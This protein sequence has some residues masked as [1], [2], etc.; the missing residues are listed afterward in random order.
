MIARLAFHIKTQR[1]AELGQRFVEINERPVMPRARARWVGEAGTAG[2]M[3]TQ[4]FVL[5]TQDEIGYAVRGLTRKEARRGVW[6]MIEMLG[7]QEHYPKR[8]RELTGTINGSKMR[9]L[10][11]RNSGNNVIGTPEGGAV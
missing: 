5:Y 4:E 3:F 1:W 11:G 9:G 7:M 8:L 2:V 10:Q 6:A